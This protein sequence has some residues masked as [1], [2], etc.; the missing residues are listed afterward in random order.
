MDSD[1]ASSHLGYHFS[2]VGGSGPIH[3]KLVGFKQPCNLSFFSPDDQ[4]LCLKSY[5]LESSWPVLML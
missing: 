3:L 4:S 2:P 1:A 5:M